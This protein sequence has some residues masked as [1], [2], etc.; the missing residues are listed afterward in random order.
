MTYP[1]SP[2]GARTDASLAVPGQHAADHTNEREAINA[3]VAELGAAPQGSYATVQ[4][5][6]GAI[7][8]RLSTWGT[9]PG[10]V[11]DVTPAG[12]YPIRY[13]GVFPGI[14]P[15]ADDT[16]RRQF[17]TFARMNL[18]YHGLYV[19]SLI[20]TDKKTRTLRIYNE[21]DINQYTSVALPSDMASWDEPSAW[22]IA[23]N[24]DLTMICFGG[25]F[26]RSLAG[27]WTTFSLRLPAVSGTAY[28]NANPQYA[29]GYYWTLNNGDFTN[30]IVLQRILT[31]P[32]E[33]IA[34]T[35][36]TG[37]SARHQF[38]ISGNRAWVATWI[39]SEPVTH[40]WALRYADI[41]A[42]GSLSTWK[43]AGQVENM[44]D[45][46]LLS[47]GDGNALLMHSYLPY[48]AMFSNGGTYG[49]VTTHQVS[50]FSA[51]GVLE[52]RFSFRASTDSQE[53]VP[54]YA[55]SAPNGR[56]IL[57]IKSHDKGEDGLPSSSYI[58]TVVVTRN[59]FRTIDAAMETEPY[60]GQLLDASPDG[61]VPNW[62]AGFGTS[63]VVYMTNYQ[64]KRYILGV[65]D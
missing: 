38:A 54:K 12:G 19:K 24:G 61:F 26:K 17:S 53:G 40:T 63:E 59:G 29:Q 55:I 15:Y 62:A 47:S 46:R 52:T 2:L 36:F 51:A 42:D 1:P 9:D 33:V 3:I 25:V 60:R 57:T 43:R 4:A 10:D 6:I 28:P 23:V 58:H 21:D 14:T 8:A 64:L 30:S 11:P 48:T 5:R 44:P 56:N 32:T 27:V 16:P 20:I 39:P 34:M 31:V 18:G 49:A 41:A 7:E 13:D 50:T 65:P 35:G 45:M 22:G 37:E